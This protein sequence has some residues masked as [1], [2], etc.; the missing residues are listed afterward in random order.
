[1]ESNST[2]TKLLHQVVKH[3]SPNMNKTP[4]P[5]DGPITKDGLMLQRHLKKGDGFVRLISPKKVA[6]DIKEAK[7]VGY[8]IEKDDISF[9]IN[10]NETG[11]IVMMGIRVNR[12]FYACTFSK[13]YWVEP[14][15]GDYK[16]EQL[17]GVDLSN[18]T[19][20]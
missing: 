7:R 14:M 18:L 5:F 19:A 2:K 6:Q 1:M 13:L 11:D 20:L 9:Y 16:A 3:F 8:L 4:K 17:E 10:D 12:S 15:G